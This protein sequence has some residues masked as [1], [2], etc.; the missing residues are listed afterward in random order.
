MD[1]DFAEV[2]IMCCC[3][4]STEALALLSSLNTKTSRRLHVTLI[5]S[6][7]PS[8]RELDVQTFLAAQRIL[9]DS[10]LDCLREAGDLIDAAEAG[11]DEEVIC[12]LGTLEPPRLFEFQPTASP[13]Q[14]H[15]ET[16]MRT[17]TIYKSV[18]I[19]AMDNAIAQTVLSMAEDLQSGTL[20]DD[21]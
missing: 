17:I 10:K 12:E 7:K 9:V 6:Y 8:M 21:L 2:D 18:G 14:A 19:S 3:T 16:G 15:L 13:G 11:L 1:V 4:P 5:G 20:I